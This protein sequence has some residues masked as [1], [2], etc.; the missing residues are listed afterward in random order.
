MVSTKTY[1]NMLAMNLL[2]TH[3]LTGQEIELPKHAMLSAADKIE[4]YLTY[5]Q[6]HAQALEA[7]LGDFETLILLGRGP[8]MSTVWNGSLIN[9]EAAKFPLEGMHAA[10]FRHGPLE[11]VVPGFTALIFAGYVTTRELNHKLALEIV[12]HGGRAFWIDMK[13]DPDLSTISIPEVDESLR[14]L[15]EIL[16]MQL[17][18]LMLAARKNVKAGQFRI[19]EKVTTRE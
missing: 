3:L 10:D 11:L 17:M 2:A 16:P 15:A 6:V 9:K 5:W 18:T 13:T 7:A 1:V 8:S 19:I 12:K 14:P 4:V